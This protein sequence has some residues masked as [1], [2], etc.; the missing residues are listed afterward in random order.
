M[1]HKAVKTQPSDTTVRIA[2]LT[3]LPAVLKQLGFDPVVV[4]AEMGFKLSLFDNPENLI[5]Y[6]RRSELIQHCVNKTGC[7]HLGH[8]IGKRT[9][10]SSFGLVGLLI[11]QS[12]DVSTAL[13]SFVRYAHLHVRGGVVY[14][15][16]RDGTVFLGYSIIQS[17]VRAIE[18]IE[19]GAVAIIF[20]I[21]RELCG[22]EWQP[23]SA[24]FAHRKPKD[25][26]PF[27]QFYKVPLNYDGEKSGILFSASSLH[28]PVMGSNPEQRRLIQKQVNQLEN[29]F[30]DDF[31]EQVRR[32]LHPALLTQQATID[33]VA[34]LFSIHQRTMNRRLHACGINF[35]ELANQSRFEIAKQLLENSS[36]QLSQIAE[37]LDY[38]GI[39]A[40]GRAFRGWSGT[41][42]SLWREQCQ[43]TNA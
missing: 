42:P 14:M 43:Q 11:Q 16:E 1:S 22:V 31:A 28:K 5:S 27:R 38:S 4:L 21:L 32:V 39:S 36:M 23:L 10:L 13:H 35:Q 20:N 24:H 8:L 6:A 29:L 26:R 18:Q 7:A 9:G 34:A 17:G 41:T 30:S 37:I 25:T 3:A 19:D 40:F 12:P 2:T 33:Q 15:E